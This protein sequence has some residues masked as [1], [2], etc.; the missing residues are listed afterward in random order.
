M[1][2]PRNPEDGRQLADPDLDGDPRQHTGYH[3]RRQKVGDPTQPKQPDRRH[4]G[5]DDKRQERD[6]VHVPGRSH[7]GDRGHSGANDGGNRRV[8]AD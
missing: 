1:P 7:H 6:Q 5:S 8:R 4:P 3:R 2:P